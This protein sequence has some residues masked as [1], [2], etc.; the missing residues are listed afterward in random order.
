MVTGIDNII[1]STNEL[2]SGDSFDFEAKMSG[3]HF[4]IFPASLHNKISVLEYFKHNNEQHYVVP[5]KEISIEV[6]ILGPPYTEIHWY[7]IN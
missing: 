7:G 1:D 5:N 2:S 4:K 6:V 3:T